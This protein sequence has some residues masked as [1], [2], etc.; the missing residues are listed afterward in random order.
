MDLKAIVYLDTDD[1]FGPDHLK[2]LAD[3]IRDAGFP[4]AAY[5]DDWIWSVGD[6]EWRL[7]IASE[8][9]NNGL[10]TS[11]LV[12]ARDLGLRWPPITYRFP[13]NGYDQDRQF[14]AV[15]KKRIGLVRIPFGEYRVHHIPKQYDI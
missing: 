1:T 9:R 6:K 10:G 15:L 8:D 3:G 14:V 7:H 2:R 4:G 12:H 13:S 5:F 11:N